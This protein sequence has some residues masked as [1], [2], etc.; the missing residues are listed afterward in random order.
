MTFS[1]ILHLTWL[2][3]PR[4]ARVLCAPALAALLCATAAAQPPTRSA[5]VTVAAGRVM[6]VTLER[7]ER[8][9]PYDVRIT[10]VA[11]P[12]PGT[13]N[14]VL[15]RPQDAGQ[16]APDAR[17]DADSPTLDMRLTPARPDAVHLRLT[18]GGEVGTLYRVRVEWRAAPE[19]RMAEVEF[20]P[21]PNQNVRPAGA[22]VTAVVVH[23]TVTPTLPQTVDWF[24]TPRSQVSAHYVVGRDGH[25]VQMVED[26]GRAWHAGV[27]VLDGVTNVNGFSVGI[28]IVNLNDGHDPFTDAQYAAV[29]SIIRHLREQYAIPDSRIVSHK[30]VARPEGRKSD[31]V[32]FDFPRLFRMLQPPPSA[33]ARQVW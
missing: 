32:G 22:T 26:T 28:E 18:G 23:A 12:A 33:D 19:P 3:V 15:V 24:L 30:F 1:A 27:S 7:L 21:S 17:L 10:L 31:P 14:R 20:I 29:A 13:Q 11:P 2:R 4:V 16:P 6:D 25:I 8:G 9:R 5:D